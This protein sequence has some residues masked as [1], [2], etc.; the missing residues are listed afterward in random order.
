MYKLVIEAST[1]TGV[2]ASSSSRFDSDSPHFFGE[3]MGCRGW[4]IVCF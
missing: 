2:Q 3:G 1:E 4:G